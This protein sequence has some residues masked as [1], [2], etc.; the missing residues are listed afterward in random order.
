MLTAAGP[1][2]SSNHAEKTSSVG[3]FAHRDAAREV[4]ANAQIER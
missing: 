4:A 2:W 1:C 3:S